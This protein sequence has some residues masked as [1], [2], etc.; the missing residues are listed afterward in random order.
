MDSFCIVVTNP[1]SKKVQFVLWLTN[2]TSWICKSGFAS[3]ILK[4]LNSGFVLWPELPKFQPVF[5]NPTNPHKS[6]QILSTIARNKSLW[7][8]ASRLTNPDSQI[9]TFQICIADLICGTF[10][11]RFVSWI[12][13]VEFFPKIQSVDSIRKAKNSK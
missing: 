13:F 1:D 9:Q 11:I 12:Q 7:I 2:P 6:W 5:T 3:P 10:F 4:D 8:Q